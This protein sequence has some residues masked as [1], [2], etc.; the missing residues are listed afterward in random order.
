[1]TILYKEAI[2]VNIFGLGFYFSV[3]VLQGH[4]CDENHL[5]STGSDMYSAQKVLAAHWAGLNTQ[6]L[7]AMVLVREI[8]RHSK[9]TLYK[10]QAWAQKQDLSLTK[11]PCLSK[12]LS[13]DNK[14]NTFQDPA[15]YSNYPEG[16][17]LSNVPP[18]TC[19]FEILRIP[20]RK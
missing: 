6:T 11:L 9:E 19:W 17:T 8:G 12:M 15:V 10:C 13:F 5:A 3:N 4:G 2:M 20:I 18:D 16:A 1:M 7:A 14:Y